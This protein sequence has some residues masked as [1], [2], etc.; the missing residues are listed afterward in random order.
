MDSVFQV[1]TAH[2]QT[3]PDT[4]LNGLPTFVATLAGVTDT[5]PYW[6]LDF[7]ASRTIAWDVDCNTTGFGNFPAGACTGEPVNAYNGF[8]GTPLPDITGTFSEAKFGGYIISGTI[9]S[10]KLC[11]GTVNCKF[12][13][14]YGVEEVSGNNWLFGLDAAYGTIGMGPGSFIWEGFIDPATYRATYSIEL[15]RV[16]V[17]TDNEVG[18]NDIK[19]N[20]TFGSANDAAYTGNP[21]IYMPS[22]SNYSYGLDEFAFGIVY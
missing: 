21:S 12:V 11:F 15:A 9:Y 13:Q 10:S 2:L 20:I 7:S 5:D 18:A 16:S 19:S 22:L 3:D 1:T 6:H 17:L 8:D 14:T 4:E